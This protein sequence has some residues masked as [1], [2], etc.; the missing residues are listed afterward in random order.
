MAQVQSVGCPICFDEKTDI[1]T[2]S[3]GHRACFDC[4]AS[5]LDVSVKES[6]I[7]SLHCFDTGCRRN[8]TFKDLQNVCSDQVK[9]DR[10][11]EIKKREWLDRIS[12]VPSCEAKSKNFV[13]G[14]KET[15]EWKRINTKDCPK[16]K[17]PILKNGGC[18]HMTCKKCKYEFCWMCLHSWEYAHECLDFE[19]RLRIAV[20]EAIDIRGVFFRVLCFFIV[21]QIGV[22]YSDFK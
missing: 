15:Q 1:C 11:R 19:E 21:Y 16:C 22:S 20:N 6:N 18:E 10:F 4:M 8:F 9:L 5:M 13:A 2:L 14:E 17:S 12:V 3:C 7:E